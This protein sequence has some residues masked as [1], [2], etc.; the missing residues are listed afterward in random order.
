VATLCRAVGAS[1]SGLYAWL[2]AIPVIQRRAEVDAALRGHIGQ[3]FATR[4]QV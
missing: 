1:V 3:I 4:R 2:Q